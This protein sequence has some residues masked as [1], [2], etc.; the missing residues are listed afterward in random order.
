MRERG[1]GERDRGERERG[2]R[3][4]R[5]ERGGDIPF[6]LAFLAILQAS[7]L[8]HTQGYLLEHPHSEK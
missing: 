1:R 8:P 7:K 6:L 3:G 2:E 4:A 5:G